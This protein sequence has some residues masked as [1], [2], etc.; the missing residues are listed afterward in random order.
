[1]KL[2]LFKNFL[3][4][5]MLIMLSTEVSFSQTKEKKSNKSSKSSKAIKKKN[6]V[7]NFEDELITGESDKPELF[8]IFQKKQFNFKKLIKLRENFLPEM[9]NTSGDVQQSGS[10]N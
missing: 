2:G 7:L 6:A 10:D 8:F 3:I 4:V 9:K 1:M 5:G